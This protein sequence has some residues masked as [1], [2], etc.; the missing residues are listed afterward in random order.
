[1][2]RHLEE[3]DYDSIISVID[4]WWGGREMSHLLPRIFFT[5]FRPTSFAV[6]QSGRV[7]GFLAG[8]VSQTDPQQ[9]YIHF[10][11]IHPEHRRRGLGRRLY[12][13][14][15]DTV[16]GLGCKIVRCI[17]SPVN[18]NSIAFHTRMGFK[19]EHVAGDCDG[20]PCTLNYELN[21]E[22]RVLFVKV[23]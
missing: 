1:M 10:V 22:N 2:I 11:G 16:G 8:F 20:V 4:E 18:R 6:E 13:H 14:F 5:H 9:A 12:T 19:I 21:G 17:T 23:L 3:R 7:I 15:F